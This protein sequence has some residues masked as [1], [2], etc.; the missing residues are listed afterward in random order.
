LFAKF[1]VTLD[2]PNI[3]ISLGVYIGVVVPLGFGLI[4]YTF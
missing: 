4:A 2:T 3:A 1:Y